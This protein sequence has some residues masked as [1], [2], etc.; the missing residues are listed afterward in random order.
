MSAPATLPVEGTHCELRTRLAYGLGGN[1]ADSLADIDG[2]T[3]CKVGAIA[4]CANPVL[5][6]A[7]EYR[8]DINTLDAGF[9]YLCHML[10]GEHN[11]AFGDYLA[12]IRVDYRLDC[13]AAEYSVTQRLYHLG[14][15]CD[16]GNPNTVAGSAV[17]FAD[18][19]VRA[20]STR[21]RV[22]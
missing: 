21:R 20:T 22:R 6:L 12:R 11:V 17:R 16:G 10:L 2:Q 4:A 13:V 18:N 15:V 5:G 8:A 7:L 1:N 14:T 9:E 19:D 3:G